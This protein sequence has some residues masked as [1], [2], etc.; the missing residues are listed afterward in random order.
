[1]DYVHGYVMIRHDLI[2]FVWHLL[3]LEEF[4]LFQ[5][6]QNPVARDSLLQTDRMIDI[7]WLNSA[8]LIAKDRQ[9]A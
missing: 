6:I 2:R 5:I 1:M 7:S 9:G 4:R 3:T 8:V